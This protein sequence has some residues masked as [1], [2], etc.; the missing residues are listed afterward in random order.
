MQAVGLYAL[1]GSIKQ[2][3]HRFKEFAFTSTDGH[4]GICGPGKHV[5]EESLQEWKRSVVG[6]LQ[7]GELIAVNVVSIQH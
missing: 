2:V 4:S 7:V 5:R 3:T 1:L 6:R